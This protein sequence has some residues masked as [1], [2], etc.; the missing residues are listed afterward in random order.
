SLLET[1]DYSDLT[2]KCGDKEFAV[3]KNILCTRSEFFAAACKPEAFKVRLT[4]LLEVRTDETDISLDDPEAVKLMIDFL[5]CHDY[6]A[7]AILFDVGLT[8]LTLEFSNPTMHAKMYVLGSKYSIPSLQAVELGKSSEAASY[9]WRADDFVTTTGLVYTSTQ[10]QDKSL[11]DIV[12]KIII[13]FMPEMDSKV[14]SISGLAY[15]LLALQS[16]EL[17][18]RSAGIPACMECGEEFKV[19][20]CWPHGQYVGCVCDEKKWPPIRIC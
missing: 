6:E 5:Y 13:K 2:I 7:P 1:G 15:D 10:E 20:Y 19:K 9:N 3:H 12:A 16:A 14:R 11:R 17:K 8:S 18:E 4:F